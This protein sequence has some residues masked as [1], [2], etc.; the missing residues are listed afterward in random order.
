MKTALLW[1]RNDLRLKDNPI[2]HRALADNF[3]VICLYIYDT[4]LPDEAKIKGAQAWWLHH[5]LAALSDQ[6]KNLGLTLIIRRGEPEKILKEMV[7][8]QKIDAVFWNRGFEPHALKEEDIIARDLALEKV[9]V[10]SFNRSL[11]NDPDAI[12]NKSGQPYQVYTAYR[13]EIYKNYA[14][15]ANPL[16]YDLEA[17]KESRQKPKGIALKDLG[18]LPKLDWDKEFKDH[19]CPGEEGAHKKLDNFIGDRLF[20]YK[21]NRDFPGLKGTSGLSPHLHFGEIS[22]HQVWHRVTHFA[23]HRK[24][25]D[26]RG[27]ETFLNEICWR[28]FCHYLLYHFPDL[29][30][31]PLQKKFQNFPWIRDKEKLEAWQKGKTGIPMVDAGMRQLWRHGWLHNR[32]RMIVGSF[33]T[34]NLLIEWQEGASWFQDCLVDADL[35]NNSGGWQWVAGCGA[36]AQPFFRIFNPVT[37][38]QRFDPEGSYIKKF[39]P[40]LKDLPIKYLHEPWNAP[41]D[42]LEKANIK[43]GET[44][45]EPIVNLKASRAQALEA[46][47][48]IR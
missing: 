17:L 38:G 4:A 43:L 36:D 35:A 5:S 42:I 8:E 10:E 37:Q 20:D 46:Y 2:I 9:Q 32:V 19:W 11:L 25:E 12:K 18:L 29:P 33:L 22:P 1:F 31:K 44:Y 3:Q 30:T 41:E 7:Q 14:P 23:A 27:V 48:E 39:I 45:P 28:E 24:Q 40:E 6:L 13:N 16:R 15:H 47:G 34:K 21:N 26:A